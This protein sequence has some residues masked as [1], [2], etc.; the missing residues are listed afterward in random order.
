MRNGCGNFLCF[1]ISMVVFAL[2]APAMVMGQSQAATTEDLVRRSDVIAV[3]KVGK[4]TS[5]WTANKRMI[6]TRIEI[7]VDEMIKGESQGGKITVLVPGGE[8]NGIGEWYSHT[9]RF[10]E[11]EN[12]VVFAERDTK[13]R[14]RVSGGEQGKISVQRDKSTGTLMIPNVG[15][16]DQ[17]TGQIQSVV[18]AQET[19]TLQR[20]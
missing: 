2:A 20:K 19:E 12:V 17:F 15:S 13:G 3:G 8:V 1:V 6:V 11:Q 14:F 10:S 16:L 18:K 9:P 7:D 5:E 4:L